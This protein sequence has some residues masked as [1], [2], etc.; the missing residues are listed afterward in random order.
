MKNIAS[1]I[2]CMLLSGFQM[3]LLKTNVNLWLILGLLLIKSMVNLPRMMS[4]KCLNVSGESG[5]KFLVI[6]DNTP[7]T[8]ARKTLTPFS[9]VSLKLRKKV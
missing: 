3:I 1:T 4:L 9:I 2:G 5:L 6:L 8:N 7:Q